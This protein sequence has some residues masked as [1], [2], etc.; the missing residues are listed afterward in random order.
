MNITSKEFEKY[1]IG[2]TSSISSSKSSVSLKAKDTFSTGRSLESNRDSSSLDNTLPKAM[3]KHNIQPLA[4]K[5]PAPKDAA[6]SFDLNKANYRMGHLIDRRI[7]P[8][9]S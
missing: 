1:A 6:R 5:G 8:S 4:N 9:I 7:K 2:I 3:D